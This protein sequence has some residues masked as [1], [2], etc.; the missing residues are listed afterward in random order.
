MTNYPD[1][2]HNPGLLLPEART[3]I[4]C[5]FPYFHKDK[6]NP[7]AV[8]FAMYAHGDD[9][10]EVLRKRLRPVCRELEARGFHHRVCVDSAP[11]LERYWAVQA[12]VGFIGRNRMLIVPGKG[13]Y[14]FLAEILTDA[15]IEPDA[16]CTDSCDG[17][18]RCVSS[19][20]GGALRKASGFDA[21]CCLS[22]LTIE[23]RG[24]LPETVDG[25]PLRQLMGNMIYGCDVC[26][27]VCP[28]NA[29]CEET[30]IGEFRL[31]QQL[32]DLSRE[33]ILH[34]DKA[35]FAELFRHSAVK[36]IRL[37]GLQRNARE[38]EGAS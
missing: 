13:S 25:R 18:M 3:V 36:R 6:E 4:V 31:R 29:A 7:A 9:Y 22:Y 27:R 20:P 28:H 35:A 38:G 8:E 21:R 37:D 30:T 19:C 2:R 16:P 1:L 23:H 11:I 17:C 15:A 12:G 26:Q 33:D 10:H 5:A 34:M 14:F 32:K 24:E